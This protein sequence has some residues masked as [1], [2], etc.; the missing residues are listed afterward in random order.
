MN[1]QKYFEGSLPEEYVLVKHVDAKNINR[2]AVV[3]PVLS[4]L[5]VF[6]SNSISRIS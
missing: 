2:Q 5:D 4:P 3:Y 6:F 1:K